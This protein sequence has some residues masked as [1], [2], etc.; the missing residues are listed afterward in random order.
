MLIND[1]GQASAPGNR[2]TLAPAPFSAAHGLEI[3][4]AAFASKSC[5]CRPEG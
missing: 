3:L 1:G 4:V 2:P 5:V